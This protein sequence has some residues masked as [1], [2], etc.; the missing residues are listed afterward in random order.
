MDLVVDQAQRINIFFSST[1]ELAKNN[2]A[3]E[4]GLKLA[5]NKSC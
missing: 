5:G 4:V 1:G 2:F 3:F